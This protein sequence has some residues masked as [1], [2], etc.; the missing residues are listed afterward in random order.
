MIPYSKTKR[1]QKI[2]ALA[3]KIIKQFNLQSARNE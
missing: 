3:Q 2:V 1:N